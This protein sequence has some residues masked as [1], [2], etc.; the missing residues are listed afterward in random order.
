[1]ACA[2]DLLSR[3]GGTAAVA[4]ASRI[5]ALLTEVDPMRHVGDFRA[6]IDHYATRGF[7]DTG[8]LGM[9]GFCFG[10]GVTWRAATQI[11]ELDA[12]APYYGPPPPLDQVPNIRAA[13]LGVYSDDPNDFANEGRAEL[14]AAL[15]AAGVTYQINVY[16][17]TQH[18]FHNDTGARWNEEQA[19]AAWN[20]TVAWFARAGLD[21]TRPPARWDELRQTAKECTD[22]DAGVYGMELYTE[23]GEG[24][25]WQYQVYLWQAGGEFLTEDLSRAAFNSA[26]GERALRFWVDLLQTDRSAPLA[27]WGQF[28]QGTACMAMD[29]SWIYS[30]FPQ[31]DFVTSD[32]RDKPEIVDQNLAWRMTAACS[33]PL[34]AGLFTATGSHC[35][36]FRILTPGNTRHAHVVHGARSSTG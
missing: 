12:A 32:W 25:T 20:D 18:A 31:D 13:V 10:G 17:N 23:P 9:T 2:V 35:S 24:L 3:E 27:P 28:G 16:P 19:L 4:D 34:K 36:L 22:R 21:P 14:E 33:R 8:R 26:A 7:A 29:G 11:A 1:V 6:A 15:E 30:V 5:P